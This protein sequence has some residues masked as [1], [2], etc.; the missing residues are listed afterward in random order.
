MEKFYIGLANGIH[1]P[2]MAVVDSDG[3]VI[4]A[5]GTERPLQNKRAVG[6]TADLRETVR[7]VIKEHCNPHAEFVVAKPLSQR[8]HRVLSV[9][10]LVGAT[11]HE[12]LPRRPGV[13]TKFLLEKNVLFAETWLAY[14]SICSSG[15][16]IADILRTEFG[17]GKVSYVK[18]DHHYAHAAN[19]SFTSPFDEAV[20]MIVDGYG[21]GGSISYF[22]YRKGRLRERHR[23]KGKESLGF[24]YGV[25]TS[26]CGFN[27]EQGEEWKLM[28]LAPYG[29]LDPKIL[30]A[31]RSLVKIDGLSIRYPSLRSVKAWFDQMKTFTREKKASPMDLADLAYT[32]QHFYTEVMTK[33][34]NNLYALRISD[35]LTI[36]G[37]CALNSSYNGQIV[38]LT[39]FK[40][41][42]VPCAPADDGNALGAALLAYFQD[43]PERKPRGVV[44]SP[45]LGTSLS[46]RT[47]ANLARFGG[48]GKLHHLPG[49][50]HRATAEL[51]AGGKLVGWVQGRA[52]FG[53]RA[54]GNRSILA[55]P[56]PV[57]MKDRINALV[58]FREEFRPFAPS[59][60]DEFGD[61]YFE[62][63]QVS[64]YMER[65]LT[66]KESV[67]QKIPA[68]VHVN[69]TGR[70][71]SVR[72]EWNERFYDLIYAFYELTGVPL[73][74]NTSFN[75]MGKPIMHSVEDAIGLFY[76]TGLDALAI[77]DYL[78]EK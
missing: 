17:N 35:N 3:E 77:E 44:Q 23:V 74:L 2:A 49:T 66:F 67:R 20:C 25:C 37:G 27:T 57:D 36:G 52:E 22:E 16:N 15:G 45:F 21:E 72:H 5:E 65:T 76:T 63:Y 53:P 39:S 51:L 40:H 8:V 29:K 59:I 7:R 71:Q 64:P 12:Q 69:R 14:T 4:Y 61:E 48:I 78:I 30:E 42:H 58:K 55:D 54:L 19:A 34:L 50:I 41:L 11:D 38:G 24:L 31:F 47:I 13:M 73:L 70:L 56:R 68:I 10:N 33:L 26:F 32:T 46:K 9:L 6:L 43:H 1:D 18:F 62:N 75:I 60:L 28:G